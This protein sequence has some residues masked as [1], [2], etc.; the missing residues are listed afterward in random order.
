[1]R[2]G[3]AMAPF[4]QSCRLPRTPEAEPELKYDPLT[5]GLSLKWMKTVTSQRPQEAVA[6]STAL[7]SSLPLLYF[8]S[9]Y[10]ASMRSGDL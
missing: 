2:V 10:S 8:A 5:A 1:M 3:S 7:G 6:T 4:G 9:Q